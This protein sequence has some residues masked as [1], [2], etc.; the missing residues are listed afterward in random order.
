MSSSS[1]RGRH[2]S[3]PLLPGNG[4]GLGCQL[5]R[6]PP[7]KKMWVGVVRRVGWFRIE[8]GVRESALEVGGLGLRLRLRVCCGEGG[9]L[10][11]CSVM[12]IMCLGTH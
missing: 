8:D 4:D 7:W 5:E 3:S 10:D 1:R 12:T 9:I 11:L 6:M 2:I